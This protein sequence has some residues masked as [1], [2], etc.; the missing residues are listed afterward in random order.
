MATIKDIAQ[1]AGV[2]PATVSRVLNY[3]PD[4][5]VGLATKQKIFEAAERLNY[6]KHRKNAANT[7]QTLRLIQWYDDT[8][9][10]EDLYYLS[11]RL[12]IEKKAEEANVTL[13]KETW[14]SISDLPADGTIALGK[15]DEA[16][17]LEMKGSQNAL[18]LVDSDGTSQGID[19]LVV[20][21][22]SSVQK[23]I[24]HFVSHKA[25]HIA[26]L[27]GTEYTKKNHQRLKDPR[28][29][30]FQQVLEEKGY[31]EGPIIEADFS[32][33]SGYKAVK[34]Y[35]KTNP[36]VPDALFAANDALAIGALRA[37]QEKGL[38]VPE[39]I[40]VVG[41]NDV[42]VAKYVTPSLST[43]KVYTEW[44]GEL[45]VET[46]LQLSNSKAPVSR[47]IIVETELI[48]RESTK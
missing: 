23:V 2:S 35:L 43:V 8:E 44:M 48:I 3:D 9:E 20:D 40:S 18:L 6:T 47:K 37:I 30:A 27:A 33:E 13:L 31:D 42:S 7:K 4:L 15:F 39:D 26:M 11:I 36:H 16:Q 28:I 14:D 17:L 1:L 46:I 12:G 22:K 24:E 38:V 32:V 5:S 34:Q 10:L 29:M 45:A 25:Q 19:S 41:F 21:F